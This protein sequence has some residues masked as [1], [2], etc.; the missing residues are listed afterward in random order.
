MSAS[1]EV[2]PIRHYRFHLKNDRVEDAA[3]INPGDALLWSGYTPREVTWFEEVAA[4][5]ATAA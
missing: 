5:A 2:K 4:S 1:T 3:G